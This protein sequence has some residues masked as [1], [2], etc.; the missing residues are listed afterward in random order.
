MDGY[1][2]MEESFELGPIRP[3]GVTAAEHIIGGRRVSIYS[4]LD[5]LADIRQHEL[6]EQAMRRLS[7]DDSEIDEKTIYRLMEG[8]I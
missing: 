7:Q 3:P 1:R 4:R 6:V 8:F 5:D 2:G